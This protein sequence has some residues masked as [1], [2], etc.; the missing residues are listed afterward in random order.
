MMSLQF[1]ISNFPFLFQLCEFIFSKTRFKS[2]KSIVIFISF[3]SCKDS[4]DKTGSSSSTIKKGTAK[5]GKI[6]R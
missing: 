5:S 3:S 6:K 2:K 4:S 1:T